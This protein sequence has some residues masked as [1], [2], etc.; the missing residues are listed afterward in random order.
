MS[1]TAIAEEEVRGVVDGQEVVLR[2]HHASIL[3]GNRRFR[4]I[5]DAAAKY[6]VQDSGSFE[7]PAGVD[8]D[9]FHLRLIVYPNLIACTE[10]V[11]GLE[12]W[13]VK[14][15]DFL[16]LPEELGRAWQGAVARVNP[17]WYEAAAPDPKAQTAATSESTGM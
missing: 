5:D 15:E 3:V 16:L 8:P 7:A 10:L 4:L 6:G 9:E 1:A 17:Q 2:V 12:G 13:P 14:F 11:R